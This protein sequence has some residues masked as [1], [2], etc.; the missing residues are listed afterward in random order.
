[1]IWFD[2]VDSTAYYSLVKRL[3]AVTKVFHLYYG[4]RI[5]NHGIFV[6][7]D[8]L[9][10]RCLFKALSCCHA[11]DAA[12]DYENLPHLFFSLLLLLFNL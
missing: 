2:S 6:S 11:T 10:V 3:L 12:D 5:P 7:F 4:K 9:T 1:M 8:L